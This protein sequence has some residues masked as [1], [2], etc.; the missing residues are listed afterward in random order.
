MKLFYSDSQPR[1]VHFYLNKYRLTIVPNH[2]QPNKFYI[3]EQ[4]SNSLP[5]NPCHKEQLHN[6]IKNMDAVVVAVGH[7]EYREM[8]IEKL[9]KYFNPIY[10]K[11]LLIDVKSIFNKEKAEKEYDYWRL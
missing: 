8:E 1:Y 9:R 3:V 2:S 10:S 7:K 5:N 4:H 11:P 6:C